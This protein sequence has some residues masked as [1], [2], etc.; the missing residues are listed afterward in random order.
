MRNAENAMHKF[1]R[2]TKNVRAAGGA[3]TTINVCAECELEL[4]LIGTLDLFQNEALKEGQHV[5]DISSSNTWAWHRQDTHR[6]FTGT[7]DARLQAATSPPHRPACPVIAQCDCG[8]SIHAAGL[9]PCC[10]IAGC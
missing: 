1:N 7:S 4:V 8:P 6:S 10:L 9:A 3:G 5:N 2:T